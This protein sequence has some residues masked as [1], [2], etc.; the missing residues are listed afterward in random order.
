M[1]P[2]REPPDP[3]R[4]ARHDLRGKVN[5]I[6]LCVSAFEM[7]DDPAELIEFLDMIEK[8]AGQAIVAMDALD[9]ALARQNPVD[10]SPGR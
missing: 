1:D 3:L 8:A 4:K 10:I 2:A 9:A 6:K 5:A 7:I